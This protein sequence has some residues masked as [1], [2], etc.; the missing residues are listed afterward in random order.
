ML[1]RSRLYCLDRDYIV[2]IATNAPE[3]NFWIL[4]ASRQLG[5]ASQLLLGCRHGITSS[6]SIPNALKVSTSGISI[7][8]PLKPLT[9]I[10]RTHKWTP[11]RIPGIPLVKHLNTTKPGLIVAS[12]HHIISADQTPPHLNLARPRVSKRLLPLPWSMKVWVSMG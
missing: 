7:I 2:S 8:K 5:F 3:M 12:W 11:N 4:Q 10:P 1:S 9:S 6:I